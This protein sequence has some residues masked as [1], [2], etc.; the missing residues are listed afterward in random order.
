MSSSES[1]SDRGRGGTTIAIAILGVV[2]VLLIAL[3]ASLWINKDNGNTPTQAQSSTPTPTLEPSSEPPT[4]S[5][6][7]MNT[8]SICGLPGVDPAGSGWTGYMMVLEPNEW[9]LWGTTKVPQVKQVG[10]GEVADQGYPYCFAQT[11]KGA[12][13]AAAWYARMPTG[14]SSDQAITDW[15][16]YAVSTG[17]Y[18]DQLVLD[19]LN[20]TKGTGSWGNSRVDLAGFRVLSYTETDA[21]VEIAMTGFGAPGKTWGSSVIKLVWENGDWKF[22]A[23]TSRAMVSADLPSLTGFSSW[24]VSES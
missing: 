10:P 9:V 23:N 1:P 15:L 12:I 13:N 4:T 20:I 11:V 14:L 16:E 7:P 6:P 19:G 24:Y 17:A 21:E 8:G 2:I 3:A 5:A 22:D 18:H